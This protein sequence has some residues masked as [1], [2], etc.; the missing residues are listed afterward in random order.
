M[1]AGCAVSRVAVEGE[2]PV[3]AIRGRDVAGTAAVLAAASPTPGRLGAMETATIA[4][5]M[6]IGVS[7]GLAVSAVLLYRLA[8]YWLPVPPGW[9]SWR[10]L[11]RMDYV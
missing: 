9:L 8:T 11:Q 3:L 6:G 2:E 1:R 7:S 5:L 10:L 4:G